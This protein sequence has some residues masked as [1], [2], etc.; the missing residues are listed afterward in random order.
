MNAQCDR[1]P[2]PLWGGLGWGVTDRIRPVTMST[3]ECAL[4]NMLLEG[5]DVRRRL[6][7]GDR[8]DPCARLSPRRFRGPAAACDQLRPRRSSAHRTSLGRTS[9]ILLLR[10]EERPLQERCPLRRATQIEEV[11]DL[12][13]PNVHLS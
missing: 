4:S 8:H 2:P 10:C 11:L 12:E 13:F 9:A 7:P 1:F 3:N 5:C 6:R